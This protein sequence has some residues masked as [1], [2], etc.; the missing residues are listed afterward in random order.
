MLAW[1][2]RESR[3][4]VSGLLF[5]LNKGIMGGGSTNRD[6]VCSKQ[7]AQCGGN[8]RRNGQ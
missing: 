7:R 2:A 5:G 4:I 3:D 8:D 1:G 6:S